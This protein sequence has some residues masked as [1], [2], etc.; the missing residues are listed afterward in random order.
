MRTFLTVL[1]TAARIADLE[2]ALAK[3]KTRV[4]ILRHEQLEN[5]KLI[6]EYEDAAGMMVEQIRT[7]CTNN[8]GHFLAQK[9]E[10]NR[11]LQDERDAH[12]KS[13]LDRDYWFSRFLKTAEMIR[14]AHRLRCEEE[15]VGMRVA[16]GLQNEVRA[17]R[18]ALGMEPE[19][20]EEEYGWEIL[21]DAPAGVE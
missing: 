12:L 18:N 11:L 7:Y 8:E 1:Y 20:P 15:D 19:K 21:R 4:E 16:A 17:Y 3:E 10:Y 6:A 2:S 14:T 5:M 9:A 13:R